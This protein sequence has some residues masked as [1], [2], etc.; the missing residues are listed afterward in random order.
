MIYRSEMPNRSRSGKQKRN[1]NEIEV[2]QLQHRLTGTAANKT[3]ALR[4]N[5]R[6]NVY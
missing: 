3:C 1:R 6:Q 5:I 4:K 2:Q